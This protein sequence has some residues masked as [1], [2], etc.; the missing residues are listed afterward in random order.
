MPWWTR[1]EASGA[2]LWRDLCRDSHVPAALRISVR[3]G[4]RLKRL[5]GAA[6]AAGPAV[7]SAGAAASGSKPRVMRW[8]LKREAQKAV[9]AARGHWPWRLAC[10]MMRRRVGQSIWLLRRS[11]R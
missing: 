5:V 2:V 3:P 9:A 11:E 6:V 1:A 4:R 10:D 7:S 8:R